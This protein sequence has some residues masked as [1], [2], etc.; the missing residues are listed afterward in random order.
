MISRCWNQ[1]YSVVPSH[2]CLFIINRETHSLP[3][4]EGK[5]FLTFSAFL[6]MT[7]DSNTFKFLFHLARQFSVLVFEDNLTEHESWSRKCQ[8]ENERIE[9]LHHALWAMQ[10][11]WRLKVSLSCKWSHRGSGLCLNFLLIDLK[12]VII[13]YMVVIIVRN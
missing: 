1:M 4:A 6:S 3:R 10:V 5:L 11:W 2:T 13:T 9:T 7:I 8:L 12:T